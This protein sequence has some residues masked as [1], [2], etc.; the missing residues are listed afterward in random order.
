VLAQKALNALDSEAAI[1]ERVKR[2]GMES[3]SDLEMA[4]K[5]H[6]GSGV[7]QPLLASTTRADLIVAALKARAER[8]DF[9]VDYDFVSWWGRFQ[10]FRDHPEL[11]RPTLDTAEHQRRLLQFAAYFNQFE[12]D[13]IPELEKLNL[14]KTGDAADVTAVNIAVFK[15]FSSARGK[16]K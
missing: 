5:Y 10:V 2:M 16:Q 11:F 8:P 1:S 15:E 7:S 12:R 9:G 14:T 13:I 6:T 3:K 4:R